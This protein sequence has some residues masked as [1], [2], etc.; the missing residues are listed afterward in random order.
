MSNGAQTHK[1]IPEIPPGIE[2]SNSEGSLTPNVE[3]PV[4]I[5]YPQEEETDA[6]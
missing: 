6:S 3:E 2:V 1:D 4:E 5:I